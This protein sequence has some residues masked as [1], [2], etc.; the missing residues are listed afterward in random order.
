MPDHSN[1]ITQWVTQIAHKIPVISRLEKKLGM[2]QGLDPVLE[3]VVKDLDR[4]TDFSRLIRLQHEH[5]MQLMDDEMEEYDAYGDP[6][7][8]HA[9]P[10][11]PSHTPPIA[12]HKAAHAKAVADAAADA[13]GVA[14]ASEAATEIKEL[15][16]EMKVK[17]KE[18]KAEA[19]LEAAE[20]EAEAKIEQADAEAELKIAEAKKQAAKAKEDAEIA[21]EEA[22]A[23]IEAKEEEAEHKLEAKKQKLHAKQQQVADDIDSAQEEHEA[24][25]EV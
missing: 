7:G 16:S 2:L 14:E 13:A 9:G 19:K 3:S 15:K 22:E 4:V 1:R 11:H 24:A 23:E 6:I 10:L 12:H 17:A 8:E 5:K 18:A 20:E 21:K 25:I